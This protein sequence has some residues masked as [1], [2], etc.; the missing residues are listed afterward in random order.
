MQ[1]ESLQF[2]PLNQAATNQKKGD[3]FK[4]RDCCIE[5]FQQVDCFDHSKPWLGNDNLVHTP[6]CLLVLSFPVTHPLFLL[7]KY[8]RTSSP[9][10]VHY[11]CH[12]GRIGFQSA[13]TAGDFCISLSFCFFLERNI[14]SKALSVI[15]WAC[16][17]AVQFNCICLKKPLYAWIIM[18]AD[19]IICHFQIGDMMHRA[20]HKRS[21]WWW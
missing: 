17:I 1:H 2:P 13:D 8:S 18:F 5:L 11:T 10:V 4:Y 21:W 6:W 7:V 12:K 16:F 3:I 19:T 15:W 9:L 14:V 20:G